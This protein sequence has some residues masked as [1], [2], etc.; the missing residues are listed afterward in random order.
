MRYF[1]TIAILL[2]SIIIISCP[3]SESSNKDYLTSPYF[4]GMN[5][6]IKIGDDLNE[7]LD[8]LY[9]EYLQYSVPIYFEKEKMIN[10]KTANGDDFQSDIYIVYLRSQ[11][12]SMQIKITVIDE[13]GNEYGINWCPD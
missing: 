10:V 9:N 11:I 1:L 13:N 3:R 4:C 8:S 2:F 12:D 6:K 5:P 7:A